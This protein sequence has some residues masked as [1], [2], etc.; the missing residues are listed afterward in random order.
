[1]LGLIG[2]LKLFLISIVV[3]F[4]EFVVFNGL[5]SAKIYL[6]FGRLRYLD[7]VTDN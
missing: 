1:M 5:H 6:I 2:N 3:S 4:A 7:A